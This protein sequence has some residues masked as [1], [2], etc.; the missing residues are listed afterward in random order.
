M[1]FRVAAENGRAVFTVTDTGCGMDREAREK[2]FTLFFSSKGSKGTGI[3]LFISERVIQQH[4]GG[5]EVESSLGE[6]T[7]IT[8]WLPLT[9]PGLAA[10]HAAGS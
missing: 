10:G 9:Q 2:M 4:H 3:G 1:G 5:I 7:R 6:G 8:V